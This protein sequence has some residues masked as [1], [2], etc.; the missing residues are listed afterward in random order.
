MTVE[1]V[2]QMPRDWGRGDAVLVRDGSDHYIVSSVDA[3]F[4]G[5]ETLVFR[6]D[7]NGEVTDWCEVAGGRG[8]SRE[9]AIA[10]LEDTLASAEEDRNA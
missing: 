8:M 4:S 5:F 2:R 9:E 7:D 10:D 1:M 3:P 6:A